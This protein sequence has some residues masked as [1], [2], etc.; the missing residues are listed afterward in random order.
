[1]VTDLLE[2]DTVVGRGAQVLKDEAPVEEEDVIGIG[3]ESGAQWRG[4]G[5]GGLGSSLKGGI[6]KQ[7]CIIQQRDWKSFRS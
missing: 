6:C 4:S 7:I 5:K 1:M 2:M 3:V